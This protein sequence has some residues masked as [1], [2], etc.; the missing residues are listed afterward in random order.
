[1]VVNIKIKIL[2]LPIN[3]CRNIIYATNVCRYGG[4]TFFFCVFV[5][6]YFVVVGNFIY[7][8]VLLLYNQQY[9]VCYLIS[10]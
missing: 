8:F 1:M 3:M 10:D 5:Y 6:L 7:F 4:Q 9:V 2:N